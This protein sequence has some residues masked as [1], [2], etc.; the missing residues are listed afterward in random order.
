MRR[1]VMLSL[2]GLAAGVVFLAFVGH[3]QIYSVHEGRLVRTARAMLQSGVPWDAQ[4]VTVE[5][6]AGE[7]E[8]VAA[9]EAGMTVTVNP[10]VVPVMDGRVRLEKPPLPYWVSAGAMAVLGER[11]LAVRVVPAA[12]GAAMTLMIVAVRTS[13]GASSR[14]PGIVRRSGAGRTIAGSYREPTPLPEP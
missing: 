2:L 14:R 11:P 6:P 3:M 10:W 9:E 13:A 4:R 12:L 5:V 8:P 7:G 1:R